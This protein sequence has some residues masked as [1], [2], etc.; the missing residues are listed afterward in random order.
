[1]KI[2]KEI[3][4]QI[5]TWIKALRSGEYKQTSGAMQDKFGYCCLGVGCKI[6]I[7]PELLEV[8]ISGCI[9]G[10]YPGSQHH[11]PEWLKNI[12]SD[13]EDKT[14]LTLVSLNDG[15]CSFNYIA[16]KL[17]EV[18]IAPYYLE[19]YKEC[20]ESGQM[21]GE[22]LCSIFGEEMDIFT[23]TSEDYNELM[24]EG[25][26]TGYFGYHKKFYGPDIVND[27]ETD[28]KIEREFTEQ[29]QTMVLFMSVMSMEEKN[30]L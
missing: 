11:A 15:G 28:I 14:G 19:F 9:R 7:D 24:S 6:T 12:N 29:R 1:M 26:P 20:L 27:D 16:D 17:E 5:K 18:Y 8:D 22:G 4:E 3:F 13:Y 10:G 2:T 21:P 25:L 23:P 30:M